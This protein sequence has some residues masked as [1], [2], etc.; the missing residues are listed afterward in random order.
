MKKI[1][2]VLLLCAFA[3]GIAAC[4]PEE[5]GPE[6]SVVG[7]ETPAVLELS[8]EEVNA[9]CGERIDLPVPVLRLG[10]GTE[11][12]EGVEVELL[13]SD[14]S[15]HVPAYAYADLPTFR[16]A[17]AD[18]YYAV[19][20][21]EVGDAELTRTAR[22]Y[23]SD[24]AAPEI[25]VDGVL[26]D[27]AYSA[28]RTYKTGID[29]NLSVRLARGE[30]GLSV[31]VEVSD[32]NLIYNTY[33]SKKFLQSDGF[34]ICLDLSGSFGMLLNTSC[35]K[36]QA[37]VNGVLWVSRA[38]SG[39]VLYE[40]DER[41]TASAPSAM[42]FIGTCTDVAGDE[43]KT[44]TD[45]D[46]GYTLEI[47]LPYSLLGT[48]AADV[49]GITCAHRD[50]S[51]VEAGVY[52]VG[53]AGNEYF[54]ETELPENFSEI[55]KG[56]TSFAFDQV[57]STSF[58]AL[59]NKC[60]LTGD[61]GVGKG[62]ADCEITVDGAADEGAWASAQ[63]ASVQAVSAENGTATAAFQFFATEEGLYLFASVTDGTVSSAGGGV[64][65]D[66]CVQFNI[67]ASDELSAS[68]LPG[69][70][71]TKS[72]SLTVSASG[73][74]RMTYL[75]KE[76]YLFAGGFDCTSALVRTQGGYAVEAFIPAYEIGLDSAA[77]C[78]VC[79]GLINCDGA[80]TA[81]SDM[82]YSCDRQA[83]NTYA[84]VLKEVLG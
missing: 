70:F 73:Q 1:V 41:L 78:G 36:I 71:F 4:A 18:T 54:S 25:E 33:V 76:G 7:G 62:T 5:E 28:F 48:D 84:I 53:A 68:S 13:R 69:D 40:L 42:R 66:D 16:P 39:K 75:N 77:L 47:Y 80:A 51:S 44:H 74:V 46:V 19:Y 17:A 23:A 60:Y 3:L 34:E 27:A 43:V 10:D 14:G 30:E 37:N 58:P 67:T 2:C 35:F 64:Y 79:C 6:L 29:G 61:A 31:G 57:E 15:V 11:T 81:A 38:S 8:A 26:N 55:S 20:T 24:P 22:I 50:V 83:P 52:E 63:T 45:T 9:V 49:I 72:R 82:A 12:A 56:D 32:T 65:A 21:A 59:Y